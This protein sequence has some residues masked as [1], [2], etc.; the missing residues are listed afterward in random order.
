MAA[1]PV[2]SILRETNNGLD[3][4]ESMG[5]SREAFA[6]WMSGCSGFAKCGR[7]F[8]G[9]SLSLA[10]TWRRYRLAQPLQKSAPCVYRSS[11]FL[12]FAPLA[13]SIKLR[14]RNGPEM[15]ASQSSRRHRNQ[16]ACERHSCWQLL[17]HSCLSQLSRSTRSSVA[18]HSGR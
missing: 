9:K 12:P 16:R 15:F 2:F 5:R 13:L 7:C 14:L 8:C 10:M 1:P 18:T 4:R 3:P 17:A 11:F 6:T